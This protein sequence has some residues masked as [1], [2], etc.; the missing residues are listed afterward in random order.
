MNYFQN[1]EQALHKIK[2][3]KNYSRKV[4]SYEKHSII[5]DTLVFNSGSY[6]WSNDEL[7]LGDT[8]N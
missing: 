3:K 6:S 7:L 1:M 4:G 2:E 5:G 8:E